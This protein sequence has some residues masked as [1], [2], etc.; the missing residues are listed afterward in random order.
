MEIFFRV[1]CRNI[2]TKITNSDVLLTK[3][4]IFEVLASKLY[5]IQIPLAFFKTKLDKIPKRHFL[6]Y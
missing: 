1:I 5:K 2:S 6:I 4:L 3:I